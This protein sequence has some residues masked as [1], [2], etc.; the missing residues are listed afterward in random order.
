MRQAS[1]SSVDLLPREDRIAVA[2]AAAELGTWDWDVPSGE[3]HWTP[4][5]YRMF[6]VDAGRFHATFDNVMDLIHPGDRPRVEAD[7]DDRLRGMPRAAIEFRIQRADGSVR[8]LRCRGRAFADDRGK[9]IRVAGVAEDVTEEKAQEP[10]RRPVTGE[11]SFSTRQVAQLLGIGEASVK[12]LANAGAIGFLR[13]SRKDSRRFAPEQVLEYLRRNGAN[14]RDFDSAAGAGDVSSS[15]AALLEEV[16]AGSALDELLDA[17][18]ARVARTVPV[19]FL[20]DLLARMPAMVS[21]PRKSSPAFVGVLGRPPAHAA[22]LVECALRGHGY[23]VLVPAESTRPEQWVDVVE[24]IRPRAVALLVGSAPIDRRS[25]ACVA[26]AIV[27]RLRGAAVVAVHGEGPLH[28]PR[29]VSRIRSAR[30][31]GQVL[32]G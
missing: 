13:S 15:V 9:A 25:A 27:D 14:A 12:R 8:W 28:L 23:S 19:G 7:I 22:A 17:R 30:E 31:L 4:Q 24:R 6:G 5:M 11:G 32:D 16:V 20:R 18:V 10:Q 29:G 21:E 26:A 3:I 2:V 1:S